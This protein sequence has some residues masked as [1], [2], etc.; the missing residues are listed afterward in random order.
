MITPYTE[1]CALLK[2]FFFTSDLENKIVF[3]S[4]KEIK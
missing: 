3:I 4:I 2:Y 1:L